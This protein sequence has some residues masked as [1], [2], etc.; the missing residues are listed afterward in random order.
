[1]EF[2]GRPLKKVCTKQFHILKPVSWATAVSE[3][4]SVQSSSW[5]IPPE[6]EKLPEGKLQAIRTGG[7]GRFSQVPSELLDSEA[8]RPAFAGEEGS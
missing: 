3:V 6:G 8:S 2:A 7:R 5:H 4:I 1:M